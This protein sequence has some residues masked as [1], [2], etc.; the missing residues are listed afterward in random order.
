M[1]LSCAISHDY[2]KIV[3]IV[4]LLDTM[5]YFYT[6]VDNNSEYYKFNVDYNN[7]TYTVEKIEIF[8]LFLYTVLTCFK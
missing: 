6:L 2:G 8:K 4:L 5:I 7:S 3:V 1:M